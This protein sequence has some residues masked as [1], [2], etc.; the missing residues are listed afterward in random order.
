MTAMGE[1]RHVAVG[2]E[3]WLA[4]GRIGVRAGGSANTIGETRPAGSIGATVA[5]T[6]AFHINFA[7]TAGRDETVSGW[8]T[9][10]SLTF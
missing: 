1:V 2:L 8:S 9:G 5:A 6:R 3:G 4:K 10:V 7:A